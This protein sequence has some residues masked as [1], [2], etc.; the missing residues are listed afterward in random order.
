MFFRLLSLFAGF[1][2][3]ASPSSAASSRLTPKLQDKI[4]QAATLIDEIVAVR[5]SEIPADLLS[6]ATCLIAIPDLTKGA[7]GVGGRYG[8]G[9]ASCRRAD[10]SWGPPAFI[11]V[12][13]AS[14]GLQ[15]GGE[16]TDMLLVI[17]GRDGAKW[18]LKDKFTLGADASVAGG[19]YGRTA[20]AATDA[21]LRAAILSYSRSRGAFVGVA[22]DG[23]VLKQDRAD[24]RRLY[25]RS[26]TAREL[27][28]PR[29]DEETPAIP[30]AAAAFVAALERHAPHA[31]GD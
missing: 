12:G 2:L 20:A 26:V 22:L 19:P 14:I 13:G 29:K 31:P 3:L 8:K 17:R 7:L 1:A 4:A 28:L 15:I 11:E 30:A 27:L 23:A 25:G 16:R 9:L 10:G 18:L 24:N 21:A 6:D 5:A